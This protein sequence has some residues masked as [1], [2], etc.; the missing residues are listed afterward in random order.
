MGFLIIPTWGVKTPLLLV[1]LTLFITSLVVL[2]DKN[3]LKQ[4][5][6]VGAIIVGLIVFLIIETFSP[7]YYG[8]NKILFSNEGLLGQIKIVEKNYADFFTQRSLLVNNIVQT[9]AFELEGSSYSMWRYPHLLSILSSIVPPGSDALLLG[10]GAGNMVGELDRL[11]ISVDA[12]ELDSRLEDLATKYFSFKKPQSCKIYID[13]ARHYLRTC[14]KQYDLI[15]FDM[16]KGEVQ[17]TYALSIENFKSLQ[18]NL[19]EQGVVLINFQGAYNKENGQA[20]ISIYRTL[21]KAGFNINL[22]H[23]NSA[24]SDIIFAASLKPLDYSTMPMSRISN[25][26]KP[27]LKH[28]SNASWVT[29]PIEASWGQVLTDDKPI[30]EHLN[31]ETISGWRESQIKKWYSE[32]GDLSRKLFN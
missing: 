17:P 11:D 24:V 7:R 14:K 26:C 28:F 1:S 27:F 10:F 25:C 3:F 9:K 23:G 15:I 32:N 2:F 19:T 18:S 8:P 31:R 30:L 16:I 29:Y 6:A 20:F 13:D 22:F 12:V 21:E 5:I 4:I